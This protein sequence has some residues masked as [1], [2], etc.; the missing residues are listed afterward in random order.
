MQNSCKNTFCMFK[1]KINKNTSISKQHYMTKGILGLN[2]P[3]NGNFRSAGFA[4][5]PVIPYLYHCISVGISEI[6][7]F[8]FTDT[9]KQTTHKR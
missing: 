1:N 7:Y 6:K 9:K 8:L 5:H 3:F 2:C 4:N